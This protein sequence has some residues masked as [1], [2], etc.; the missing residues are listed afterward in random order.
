[1]SLE[2]KDRRCLNCIAY[3][4]IDASTGECRKSHVFQNRTPDDWCLE[5]FTWVVQTHPGADPADNWTLEGSIVNMDFQEVD[6]PLGRDVDVKV[7]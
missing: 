4:V 2:K 5:F 1:M 6:N 7:G 3:H